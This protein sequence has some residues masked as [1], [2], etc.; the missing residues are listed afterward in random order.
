M[1]Q[2]TD[3]SFIQTCSFPRLIYSSSPDRGLDTLLYLFRFIKE[4]FPQATLHILYGFENWN[5][6]IDQRNN[7][8]EKKWRDQIIGDMEQPNVYYYGRVDQNTVAKM[9]QAADLWFYPSRFTET[10]CH[11]PISQVELCNYN[12]TNIK[13]VQVGDRVKTHTGAYQRVSSV[14]SRDYKGEMLDIEITT[15]MRHIQCTPEHPFWAVKRS[16]IECVR[17]KEKWCRK[18][19]HDYLCIKGENTYATNCKYLSVNRMQPK[20]LEAKDLNERDYLVYPIDH[21]VSDI[22]YLNVA[23]V[24]GRTSSTCSVKDGRISTRYKNIIYKAK[25]NEVVQVDTGFMRLCGYYLAEGSSCLDRSIVSFSFNTDEQKYIQEVVRLS[26]DIFGI[27]PNRIDVVDKVTNII[28]NSRILGEFFTSLF[29]K[30]ARHKSLP[31]WC[32]ILPLDKQQELLVGLF[33]GDG[34]FTKRT[35]SVKMELASERLIRQVWA[36]LLRFDIVAGLY[37]NFK[38]IPRYPLGSGYCDEKRPYYT[39]SYQWQDNNLNRAIG[40]KGRQFDKKSS[41]QSVIMDNKLFVPIRKIATNKYEGLVY[42]LEV[43]D[44]HSYVVENVATHNCITALE[45]QIS[46]TAIVCTDL[47]ALHTTVG[48]RGTLLQGDA[49][50]KQYREQALKEV[51]AILKDEKR[52]QEMVERA[53]QWAKQQTWDVRAKEMLQIFGIRS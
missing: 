22:K 53:F 43:E 37:E 8:Q 7:E 18:D 41:Q 21:S 42:N 2:E 11:N 38:K 23:Q 19:R 4:E 46:K 51:F 26:R 33:R 16:E 25:I 28:Y 9:Y 34:C 20:W 45:A 36:I 1:K 17:N 24:C 44:D 10:Y 5:K 31:D 35:N 52:R 13:D 29:G 48:D 15:A 39:L 3:F 12:M 32:I 14:L 49:Y 47:A 6:A 50:T 30:G 40:F 27:E